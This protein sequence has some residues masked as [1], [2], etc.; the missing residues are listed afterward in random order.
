MPMV[1]RASAWLASCQESIPPTHRLNCAKS[2]VS[3]SLTMLTLAPTG[4][5]SGATPAL[6][7]WISLKPHLPRVSSSSVRGMMPMS[8][9]RTSAASRSSDQRLNSIGRPSVSKGSAPTNTK[10]TSLRVSAQAL[11][12]GFEILEIA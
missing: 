3:P 6:M 10:L 5:H 11:K 1:R 2:P 4:L 7:Y 9:E 8:K 12:C